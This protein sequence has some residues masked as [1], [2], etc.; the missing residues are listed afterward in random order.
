MA[1]VDPETAHQP[2]PEEAAAIAA[3]GGQAAGGAAE[4]GKTPAQAQAEQEAAMKA[5]AA[6]G[7]VAFSDEAAEKIAETTIKMLEAR[8][9]FEQAPSTPPQS[10]PPS[11]GAPPPASGGEGSPPAPAPSAPSPTPAGDEEPRK[12]T[13]AERFQGKS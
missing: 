7:N 1:H 8:G 12:R 10:P 2:T 4:T 9:A 13:F 3:A 5:K 11:E 6:E